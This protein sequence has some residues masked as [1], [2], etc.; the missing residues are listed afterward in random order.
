MLFPLT[1]VGAGLFASWSHNLFHAAFPSIPHTPWLAGLTVALLAAIGGGFAVRY[2]RVAR[3][4]ARSVRVRLTRALRTRSLARL[5]Q[6][7][8]ELFDALSAISEGIELPGAVADD[9]RIVRD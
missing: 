7:R 2:I 9:G 8:S 5:K 1:W 4:T 6:E 3:E